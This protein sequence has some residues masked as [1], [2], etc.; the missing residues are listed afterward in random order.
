MLR[1]ALTRSV[2]LYSGETWEGSWEC[3]LKKGSFDV[4]EEV[5]DGSEL[6]TV[7]GWVRDV[8]PSAC[9]G[10]FVDVSVVVVVVAVGLIVIGVVVFV[11]GSVVV[12]VIGADEESEDCDEESNDEGGVELLLLPSD[13]LNDVLVVC[14]FVLNSFVLLFSWRS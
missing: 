3:E 2:W 1:A 4:C 6:V 5:S 10:K 7:V 13:W 8:D 9:V 14:D 11:G 12:C